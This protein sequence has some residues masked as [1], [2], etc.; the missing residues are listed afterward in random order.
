[1]LRAARP[2]S[3]YSLKEFWLT[4]TSI[5][6]GYGVIA[7]DKRSFPKIPGLDVTLIAVSPRKPR[8]R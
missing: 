8:S 6:I 2:T 7:T 1:M 3:P 5:A 4:A